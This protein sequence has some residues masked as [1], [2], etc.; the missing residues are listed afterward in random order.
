M[1]NN[2]S[3]KSVMIMKKMDKKIPIPI[4]VRDSAAKIEATNKFIRIKN[5][6]PVTINLI[7]SITLS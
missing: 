3:H 6:A 5:L 2:I 7:Y 1:K 4:C